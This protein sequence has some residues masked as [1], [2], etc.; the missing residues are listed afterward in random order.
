M[1]M[2]PIK[3]KPGELSSKKEISQRIDRSNAEEQAH[4]RNLSSVSQG[5]QEFKETAQL[6][7]KQS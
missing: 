4:T 3:L 2:P 6:G 5:I 7:K 1:G